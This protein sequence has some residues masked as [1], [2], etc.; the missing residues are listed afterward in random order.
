MTNL[1]TKEKS[2][3]ERNRAIV[4][5]QV[6]KALNYLEDMKMVHRDLKP[7]NIMY[8]ST[9]NE[10]NWDSIQ[11]KLIDFGFAKTSDND[12]QDFLG[13]PYFI[14]PEII[15]KEKY[16]TKCD[17]WSLG[18][19]AHLILTG[20]MPFEAENKNKLFEVILNAE[21]SRE[22]TF[23]QLSQEAQEFISACLTVDPS[24]RASPSDLLSFPFLKQ[25]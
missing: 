25:L 12:L 7:D 5:N 19:I 16:G 21:F 24:K 13:T 6:V 4:L 23:S 22:G 9:T 10:T 2:F 20:K 1:F 18:V 14:A 11:I 3:S 15:K 17:V 8:S